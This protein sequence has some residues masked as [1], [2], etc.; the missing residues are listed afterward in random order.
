MADRICEVRVYRPSFAGG[1][2]K[3]AEG[4]QIGCN[5]VARFEN[6]FYNPEGHG[7]EDF[8]WKFP[9]NYARWLCASHYDDAFESVKRE[10][11]FFEDGQ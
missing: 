11:E 2:G 4:D 9:Y 7:D 6:P 10:A 3:Y 1:S 8:W 5:A